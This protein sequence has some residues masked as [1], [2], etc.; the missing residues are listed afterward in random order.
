MGYMEKILHWFML[1]GAGFFLFKTHG[2]DVMIRKLLLS[3]I[4]FSDVDGRV[5][6]WRT[7]GLWIGCFASGGWLDF[8]VACWMQIQRYGTS[9]P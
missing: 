9:I 2:R 8:L 4:G 3:S 5:E 7:V 6:Q 1:L